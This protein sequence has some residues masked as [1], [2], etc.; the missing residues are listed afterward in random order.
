MAKTKTWGGK[1]EGAGRPAKEPTK[2]L[3]YRVPATQAPAIDE[4]IRKI[5]NKAKAPDRHQG[6]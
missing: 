5:I 4:S 1:R 6:R 3:S 2:T